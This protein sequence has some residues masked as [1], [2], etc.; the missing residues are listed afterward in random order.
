MSLT[1]SS[2]LQAAREHAEKLGK[3]ASTRANITAKNKIRTKYRAYERTIPLPESIPVFAVSTADMSRTPEKQEGAQKWHFTILSMENIEGVSVDENGRRY[4]EIERKLSKDARAEYE[5]QAKDPDLTEKERHVFDDVTSHRVYEFSDIALRVKVSIPFVPVNTIVKLSNVHI[6]HWFKGGKF[7]DLANAGKVE[8]QLT[9]ASDGL[10]FEFLA[11]SPAICDKPIAQEYQKESFI[12]SC[13]EHKRRIDAYIADG[14]DA[15]KAYQKVPD[16]RLKFGDIT[17]FLSTFGRDVETQAAKASLEEGVMVDRIFTNSKDVSYTPEVYNKASQKKESVTG[18]ETNILGDQWKNG[19]LGGENTDQTR[20]KI[21]AGAFTSALSAF[22][23]PTMEHWK[24][25][26]PIL[27]KNN[28]LLT[29]RENMK[30]TSAL[31][32]ADDEDDDA[33]EYGIRSKMKI[34]SIVCNLPFNLASNGIPIGKEQAAAT[35]GFLDSPSTDDQDATFAPMIKSP[36]HYECRHSQKDARATDV[37]CLNFYEGTTDVL[38]RDYNFFAVTNQDYTRLHANNMKKATPNQLAILANKSAV[39]E[40]YEIQAD[41]ESGP[42][43]D[44]DIKHFENTYGIDHAKDTKILDILKSVRDPEEFDVLVYAVKKPVILYSDITEDKL[45]NLATL[46]GFRYDLGGP[47]DFVSALSG[48]I[49]SRSFRE[50]GEES[51]EEESESLAASLDLKRPRSEDSESDN[52]EERNAK[53]S[54]ISLF[55]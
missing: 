47:G 27:L 41:G 3:F 32:T 54:K 7:L 50:P 34:E 45:V 15:E 5:R 38:L 1:P 25:F 12:R 36:H 20:F 26:G 10:F 8:P 28:F 30:E 52:S 22:R 13:Q 14:G 19:S 53:K 35:V 33:S 43:Y 48:F 4:I 18:F 16:Y 51:G 11:N 42:T 23:I 49:T 31:Q 55:E 9:I 6:S 39:K 37:I 40:Y 46:F 17:Y 21:F 44:E 24:E 2:H 29:C